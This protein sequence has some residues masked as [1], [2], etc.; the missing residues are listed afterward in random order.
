[1]ELL[2]TNNLLPIRE[3]AK[4][5]H[6]SVPYVRALIDSGSLP[7]GS[8]IKAGGNPKHPRLRVDA[9]ELALAIREKERYVPPGQS[10][11]PAARRRPAKKLHPLAALI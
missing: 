6:R 11:R 7:D 8:V 2:T 3:A 5:V 10:S 1:M 9:R 4:A